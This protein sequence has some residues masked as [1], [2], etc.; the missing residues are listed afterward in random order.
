VIVLDV[1]L[2]CLLDLLYELRDADVPLLLGGGYGLYL[3][4]KR[5]ME[6]GTPLL[7]NMVPP[8]RSTNDLDFFL[9]ADLIADSTR[10]RL[11]REA[12]DRLSFS[13]IRSAQNYQFARKFLFNGQPWDI[14]VD[15]LA[16][17]PDKGQ[18]PH[19]KVD[20]RRVRPYPSVG[21]HAHRTDEAI[22]VEDE[23]EII[24]VAGVRTTGNPYRGVIY[25]PSTYALLMMKLFALRD[26]VNDETK[27][28]GRKHALDLYT[29]VAIL[30]EREYEQTRVLSL[31]YRET[32]EA[33]EAAH[34]VASLFVTDDASGILRLREN[35]SLPA[36]AETREFRLLL[37]EFFPLG[38]AP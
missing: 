14:K 36:K 16:K 19:V 12:L 21:I 11:L 17:L 15:L 24:S 18:Y 28:F 37:G 32:E 27:G 38:D 35:D 29:L 4:Q 31:R 30:T 3:K 26:Q 22:A 2:S 23:L 13:V 10:L 25:L 8:V 1:L 6:S 5:A 7:L 33:R 9:R 20:S 34:I